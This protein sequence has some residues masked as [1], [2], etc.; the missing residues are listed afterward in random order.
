MK[1]KHIVKKLKLIDKI[2]Q[3]A[4]YPTFFKPKNHQQNFNPKLPYDLINP[5]KSKLGIKKQT[6]TGKKQ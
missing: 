3:L 1:A 2:E 4:R 6:K 5:S